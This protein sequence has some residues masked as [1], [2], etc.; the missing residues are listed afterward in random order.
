MHP[1]AG[2]T[3]AGR[4]TAMR[5][6]QDLEID[7]GKVTCQMKLYTPD[8][9]T[10]SGLFARVTEA[11]KHARRG[12]GAHTKC[13]ADFQEEFASSRGLA[14]AWAERRHWQYVTGVDIV[15]DGGMKVW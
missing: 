10:K 12:K 1:G 9:I 5:I 7:F 13:Q 3:G 2:L 15:V 4:T 14:A 8:V 11:Q 6:L